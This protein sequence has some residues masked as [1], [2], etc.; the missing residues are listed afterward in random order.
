MEPGFGDFLG[1]IPAYFF[2]VPLILGVAYI[3]VM[4]YIFRRAA[5]RR[6]KKRDAQQQQLMAQMG[7]PMGMT[8]QAAMAGNQ[9]VP[10]ARPAITPLPSVPEPDLADLLSDALLNEAD[11]MGAVLSATPAL[12]NPPPAAMPVNPPPMEAEMPITPLSSLSS[13]DDVPADAI[14]VMRIWRDVNDGGLIIQ[15]GNQRYRSADEIQSPDLLRRFTAVVRELS[16]MIGGVVAP[17][18]SIRP[19]PPAS[20]MPPMPRPASNF[21][22]SGSESPKSGGVL[23][24]LM[25]RPAA[26]PPASDQPA[27]IAA[28][29]EEYLQ[30]RLLGSP[31]FAQRS[32][33]IRPSLD[34]GI[35]IEVDNRYF[36]SIAE[37]D[38]PA[39][40]DYLLT[41]MRE[42]ES[43]Q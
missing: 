40:R 38:D 32:I 31:E 1:Q 15:M 10:M 9:F 43:R 30:S 35:K 8:P 19:L 26:P 16:A 28:S 34:H 29:V 2:I 42:W 39:V 37:V 23:N 3:A 17:Q 25:G 5:E 14:E 41:M 24:R 27:G 6:R 21:S 7:M 12:V 20:P 36:D 11:H 18:G 33:H 13:S 4:V 22:F